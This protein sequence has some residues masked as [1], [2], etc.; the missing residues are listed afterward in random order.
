MWCRQGLPAV[1]SY[2]SACN[3]LLY[4][5]SSTQFFQFIHLIMEMYK[6]VFLVENKAKNDGLGVNNSSTTPTY[7]SPGN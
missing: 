5:K 2:I 7:L 1:S 6:Y 4:N 3:S